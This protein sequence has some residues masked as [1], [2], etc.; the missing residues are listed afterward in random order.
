MED[1]HTYTIE[2]EDESTV[3]MMINARAMAV[4]IWEIDQMMRKYYKYVD[5][6]HEET[7]D[8]VDKMRE[9]LR[10]ILNDNGLSEGDLC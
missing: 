8:V 7:Y 3:K 6:K 5:H 2:T 10:S 1:K 4:S 9:E